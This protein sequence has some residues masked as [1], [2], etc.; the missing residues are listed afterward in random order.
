MRCDEM[1]NHLRQI[2]LKQKTTL[3]PAVTLCEQSDRTLTVR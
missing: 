2:I 1:K 3:D